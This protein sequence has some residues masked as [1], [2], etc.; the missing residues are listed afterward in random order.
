M[1]TEAIR[2]RLIVC[3]ECSHN[4]CWVNPRL[5]SY[6][7][8]CGK[9]IYAKLVTDGSHIRVSDAKASLRYST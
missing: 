2:F 9:H 3:P 4:L 8:E 6:C 1:T 5:P 7:P